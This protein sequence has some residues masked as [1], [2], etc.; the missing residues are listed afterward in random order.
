MDVEAARAGAKRYNLM[1]APGL[2]Q[3]FGRPCCY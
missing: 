1:E 2:A 3:G